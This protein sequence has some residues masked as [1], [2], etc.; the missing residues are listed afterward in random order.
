MFHSSRDLALYHY[1]IH[2]AL[3]VL[4]GHAAARGRGWYHYVDRGLI[5][6]AEIAL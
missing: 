6:A 2:C 3:E 5:T 1:A 4:I